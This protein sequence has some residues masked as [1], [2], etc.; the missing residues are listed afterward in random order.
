VPVNAPSFA[1][2]V[3]YFTVNHVTESTL[4]RNTPQAYAKEKSHEEARSAR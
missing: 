4:L 3:K 2:T 1:K